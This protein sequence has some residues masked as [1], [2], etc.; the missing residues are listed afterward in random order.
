[1]NAVEKKDRGHLFPAF[2][3]RTESH[4]MNPARSRCKTKKYKLFRSTGCSLA[5]GCAGKKVTGLLR[6]TGLQVTEEINHKRV[7]EIL[8]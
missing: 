3:S 8:V 2:S 4:H 5:N 1:M 7:R 6:N